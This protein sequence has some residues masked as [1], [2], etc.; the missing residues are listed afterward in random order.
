MENKHLYKQTVQ[1]REKTYEKKQDTEMAPSE[2]RKKKK[3]SNV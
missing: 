1:R 2:N 3:N